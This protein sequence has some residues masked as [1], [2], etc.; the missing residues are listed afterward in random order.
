MKIYCRHL[1]RTFHAA[2][3]SFCL[4]FAFTFSYFAPFVLFINIS[5]SSVYFQCNF[6]LSHSRRV[7][8]GKWERAVAHSIQLSTMFQKKKKILN[9]QSRDP[10]REIFPLCPPLHSCKALWLAPNSLGASSEMFVVATCRALLGQQ[11]HPKHISSSFR[12]TW[13]QIKGALVSASGRRGAW[14]VASG[15]NAKLEEF[16]KKFCLHELRCKC[17]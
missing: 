7:L 15:S 9:S 8:T 16:P 3:P 14:Q 17:I 13:P 1:F 11:Q 10:M 5:P 2:F 6:L 4:R 12:A